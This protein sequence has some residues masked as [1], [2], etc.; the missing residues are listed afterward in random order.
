MAKNKK[1]KKKNK[2]EHKKVKKGFHIHHASLLYSLPIAQREADITYAFD[3]GADVITF[4]E[5]HEADTRGAI[6]RIGR[7]KGYS[8]VTFGGKGDNAIA[9]KLKGDPDGKHRSTG[10]VMASAGIPNK[11]KNPEHP[12]LFTPKYVRWVRYAWYDQDIWIHTAH[13]IFIPHIINAHGEGVKVHTDTT[14]TMCAQVKKHG[15]GDAISFFTGDIN[16][17]EG[18]D[19]ASDHPN[20]PNFIFR[21]NGLLTIWDEMHVSPPTIHDSTFDIIGS[22]RPDKQVE[23]TRYVVHPKQNSDHRQISAYYDI[24]VSKKVVTGGGGGDGGAGEGEDGADPGPPEAF[25][26][27]IWFGGGTIDWSDYQD[28]SIYALPVAT[29]DSQY[30]G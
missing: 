18:A 29:G 8:P 11:P 13:W 26:D 20:M 19:N 2:P 23:G 3:T 25:D 12:A 4:T 22:Y 30:G 1:N 9:V 17:D 21:A 6:M 27:G 24:D 14:K 15:Q 7:A 10:G 16:I 5:A 28:D